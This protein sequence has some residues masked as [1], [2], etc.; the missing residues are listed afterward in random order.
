[1]KL[2]KC[3]KK[4]KQTVLLKI[5]LVFNCIQK[6]LLYNYGNIATFCCSYTEGRRLAFMCFIYVQEC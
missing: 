3:V 6:S 5:K 2:S 4:A 1:M